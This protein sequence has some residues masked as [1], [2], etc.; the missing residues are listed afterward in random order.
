MTHRRSIKHESRAPLS[1]PAVRPD[2]MTAAPA[3]PETAIETRRERHRREVFER[4]VDSARQLLFVRPLDVA[5]VQEITD[6]ADVGKGTFFNYFRGKD[7]VLPEIIRRSTQQL[8]QKIGRIRRGELSAAQAIIEMMTGAPSVASGDFPMF[9]GSVLSSMIHNDEV[10]AAMAVHV[11]SMC[12]KISTI[13]ELGQQR[14]EFRTDFAAAE[15]GTCIHRL[16]FGFPLVAWINNAAPG[17][18]ESDPIMQFT[19]A[20]LSGPSQKVAAVKAA[21]R[22]RT[23]TAAGRRQRGPRRARSRR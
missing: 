21:A 3:P 8:D 5:T 20:L 19:L 15:L 7:F 6:N 22:K 10:R 17:L 23:G 1:N 13:V 14:G 16:W 12:V 9:Y 2:D 11:N 4:L 18:R